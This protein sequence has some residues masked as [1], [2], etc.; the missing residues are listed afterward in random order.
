[1]LTFLGTI[2]INFY[3][4]NTDFRNKRHNFNFSTANFTDV[5]EEDRAA[6]SFG[7]GIASILNIYGC[8]PSYAANGSDE[9]NLFVDN[10]NPDLSS[11]FDLL[12]NL[13]TGKAYGITSFDKM[14][15]VFDFWDDMKGALESSGENAIAHISHGN[16]QYIIDGAAQDKL[17]A[18]L[19]RRFPVL[20]KI[21]NNTYII[22]KYNKTD[23]TIT[24][25]VY[26]YTSAPQE[27][28]SQLIFNISG[29][30]WVL[31]DN[32]TNNIYA[33]DTQHEYNTMIFDM[34]SY[35]NSYASAYNVTYNKEIGNNIILHVNAPD[36]SMEYV[37]G[38]ARDEYG[39]ITEVGF[40]PQNGVFDQE[41]ADGTQF[42][43]GVKVQYNSGHPD[44]YNASKVFHLKIYNDMDSSEWYY[45]YVM[46]ASDKKILEGYVEYN[47]DGSKNNSY[48]D[49]ENNM[50]N[51]EFIKTIIAAAGFD[52]ITNAEGDEVWARNYIEKAQELGILPGIDATSEITV[53]YQN[54]PIKRWEAAYMVSKLF[55]DNTDKVQVPTMLYKYEEDA[56]ILKNGYWRSGYFEDQ[57]EFKTCQVGFETE[58][59]STINAEEEIRQMYINGILDGYETDEGI[60]FKPDETI[61]RAEVS[62]II[63]KCLFDLDED[64]QTILTTYENVDDDGAEYID[65]DNNNADVITSGE[66][67][68]SGNKKYYFVAPKTGYYYI[69][70]I[71][72]CSI[73]VKDMKTREIRGG[74]VKN[75]A[76]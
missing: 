21:Y 19:K 36:T 65:F 66:F 72:N 6:K 68:G 74:I 7:M 63:V 4:T 1:M 52:D 5:A 22:T 14:R 38:I 64:I 71:D 12:Y 9:Y 34:Y 39:K 40:N 37:E 73:T 8:L 3:L 25:D 20:L 50:T 27:Q 31:S 76:V 69:H 43:V 45:Y 15:D 49:P 26:D 42:I 59:E 24:M 58:S 70:N 67:S 18:N 75:R 44:I 35:I 33:N 10:E 11:I 32:N 13:N 17:T 30:N 53:A 54:T 41:Q 47:E 48:F 55:L 57:N 51:G 29:D 46:E 2:C 62:K 16:D 56:N 60:F 28:E 23:K 61:S